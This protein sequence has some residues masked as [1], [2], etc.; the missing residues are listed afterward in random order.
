VY[1]PESL[2]RY[3]EVSTVD[4]GA[5]W[6]MEVAGGC[7]LVKLVTPVPVIVLGTPVDVHDVREK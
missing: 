2:S 4:D 7:P 5:S 1:D 6:V 3:V